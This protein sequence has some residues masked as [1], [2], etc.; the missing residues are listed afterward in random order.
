[1]VKG[2]PEQQVER[3]ISFLQERDFLKSA[4]QDT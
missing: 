2:T 1:M 3:I 4:E